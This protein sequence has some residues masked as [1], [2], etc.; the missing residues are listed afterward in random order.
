MG[1]AYIMKRVRVLK[2]GEI[3]VDD[4][5]MNEQHLYTCDMLAKVCADNKNRIVS[6]GL[7]KIPCGR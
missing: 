6:R 2:I 5:L 7:V 1:H 4:P 3:S